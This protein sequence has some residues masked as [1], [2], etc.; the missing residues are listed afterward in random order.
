VGKKNTPSITK[1]VISLAEFLLQKNKNIFI[2]CDSLCDNTS[3]QYNCG[4]LKSFVKN[5]D[6]VIVIGGDGTLLGVARD[7]VDYNIPVVGI[8]QGNLGFMTDIPSNDMLSKIQSIVQDNKYTIENRLLLEARVI[9]REVVI[10]KSLALN[11][12]VLSKGAIG[13]MIDFDISIN[14]EF[15]LSQKS[16][17]VIFS[18]STGSTAY[19]LA[20]GGPI[21]H[22]QLKAISI[23][24]ICPQSLSN[25]PL[26]VNDDCVIELILIK[27]NQ[28]QIHF[29][30]Q[31]Y[32]NLVEY[33]KIILTKYNTELKLLHPFGY[34]YYRTLR[35]KLGWS[36]RLS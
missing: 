35:K 28:T 22:P 17:G 31:S 11:D 30:G 4:M 29:D 8:N 1:Y 18:T 13:S 24:P 16:D 2:D 32:F 26:V 34:N 15:V 14:K 27:D 5:I 19:S 12:I 33:D 9:R 25:R 23:V 3:S 7:I 10:Y 36:K 6:L 21:L 20:A